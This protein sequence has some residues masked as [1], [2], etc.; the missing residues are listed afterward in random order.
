MLAAKDARGIFHPRQAPDAA[1]AG[2]IG[3]SG[4]AAGAAT[5]RADDP[6][7]FSNGL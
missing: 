2:G 1:D 4:N 5:T 6:P 7:A 3:K